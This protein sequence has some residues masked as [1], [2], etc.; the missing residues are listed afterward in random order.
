MSYAEMEGFDEV[1]RRSLHT[2]ETVMMR[3]GVLP[4]VLRRLGRLFGRR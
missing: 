3:R 2:F 4:R 1:D